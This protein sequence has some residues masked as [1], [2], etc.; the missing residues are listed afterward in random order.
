M[1]HESAFAVDCA[2]GGV[3]KL[4]PGRECGDGDAGVDG[5]QRRVR[6]SVSLTRSTDRGGSRS[7]GTATMP[8]R[9]FSRRMRVGAASTSSRPSLASSS[10]GCPGWNPS[11]SLS[12]LG[13]TIRPARSMVVRMASM[14]HRICH[15][16]WRG[17][18]SE[19]PGVHIRVRNPPS[20][21]EQSST[22]FAPSHCGRSRSGRPQSC[23][24]SY[25]PMAWHH[26]K[27]EK[28]LLGPSSSPRKVDIGCKLLKFR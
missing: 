15:F 6:S 12:G 13:M 8:R 27:E 22:I 2:I 19:P 26:L 21:S 3:M 23:S 18:S 17:R 25:P 16:L 14:Y 4:V 24:C 1:A 20:C 10:K 11:S 5:D 9:R 7:A 28:V